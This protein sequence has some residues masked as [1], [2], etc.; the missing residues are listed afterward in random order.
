MK[1]INDYKYILDY[2]SIN[3]K[4]ILGYF[5]LSLVVLLLSYLTHKKSDKLLFSCY[6]SSLL[7]PLSYLRLFT[8]SLG[9]TSFE[10]LKNNFICILLI[11]PM[12]EEKIGSIE[13]LKYMI[14]TAGITGIV[15]L[16][17]EKTAIIG[18]SNISYLLIV[19]SSFV[20]ITDGKIPI[21]LVL[22]ILFYV[23]DEVKSLLKKDG[24]SHL[25]H[26][27]GAICGLVIGFMF[28]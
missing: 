19:L 24:I 11:G 7:N 5:V 21:T 4:V 16:L 2:F 12:L 13:L 3:S 27:T 14:I 20:N 25:G 28:L 18:A 8:H 6:R 10:H 9:H 1:Y 15:H 26:L 22:I 17:F 23:I